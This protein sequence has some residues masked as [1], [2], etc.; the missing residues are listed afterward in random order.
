MEGREARMMRSLSCRPPSTLSRSVKPLL[1]PE[2]P[3]WRMAVSAM[4]I[5][6]VKASPKGVK[7][8]PAEPVSAKS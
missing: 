2:T 1:T 3:L 7:S 6:R 4:V 5:D 8:R